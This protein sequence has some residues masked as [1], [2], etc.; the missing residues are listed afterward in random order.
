M[1]R[2]PSDCFGAQAYRPNPSG[3]TASTSN[4]SANEL[5]VYPNPFTEELTIKSDQNIIAFTLIDSQGKIIVQ[6][7]PIKT[8]L[9]VQTTALTN[10]IYF[11]EIKT[12]LSTQI[13]K[14]VK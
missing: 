1:M 10:G 8:E 3:G 9:Q 5:N 11:L 2:H 6:D 7:T 14:V 13:I 12:D 4:L